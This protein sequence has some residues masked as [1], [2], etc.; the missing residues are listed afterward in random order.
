M[1]WLELSVDV[2]P[3]AVESISELLAHY[4]YNGGVVI[5]QPIITGADGADYTFDTSRP[6][7]TPRKL[8][9]VS[10]LADLGWRAP[11][12]LEEGLRRYYAWYLANIDQLRAA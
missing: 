3:E 10:R 6:D 7:G 5:D 2:E 11:T 8:L 9:D 12:S 1:T 4:G